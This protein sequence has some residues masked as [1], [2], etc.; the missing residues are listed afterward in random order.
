MDN[1]SGKEKFEKCIVQNTMRC[2]QYDNPIMK[3]AIIE[4]F[5]APGGKGPTYRYS[6]LL[7]AEEEAA[8]LCENCDSFRPINRR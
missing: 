1:L 8:K 6:L 2:P 4:V 3:E 5:K 7:E